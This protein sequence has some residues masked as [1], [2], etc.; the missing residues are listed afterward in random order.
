M[1]DRALSRVVAV[2]AA[3][4][5][6][7][8]WLCSRA[9]FALYALA[10]AYVGAAGAAAIVALV[11]ALAVALFALFAALRARAS[12]NARK[13]PRRRNIMSNLPAGLGDLVR[14]RPMA[15]LAVTLIGGVVAARHPGLA[16]DLIALAA[17]FTRAAK[18]QG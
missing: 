5:R 11:A 3:S 16:R 14:D 17:R 10:G 1:F 9:G 8:S 2:A 15:S 12:A 4:A 6:R 13:L 18:P 7:P